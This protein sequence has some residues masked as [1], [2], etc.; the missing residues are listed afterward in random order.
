MYNSSGLPW[1]VACQAP[2]SMGFSR[3]DYCMLFSRFSFYS[4]GPCPYSRLWIVR[5]PFLTFPSPGDLPDPGVEPPSPASA[6]GR[7]TTEPPGKSRE[8]HWQV[9]DIDSQMCQLAEPWPALGSTI[10]RCPNPALVPKV[11][12]GPSASLVLLPNLS[13]L[14]T[15]LILMSSSVLFSVLTKAS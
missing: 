1:T 15:T 8:C 3:Q 5:G 13:V 4:P 9:L 11:S 14:G 2:L 12:L 6:G 7:F 10:S